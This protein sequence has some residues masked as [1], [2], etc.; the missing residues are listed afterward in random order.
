MVSEMYEAWRRMAF[1]TDGTPTLSMER[2]VLRTM[3]E[4]VEESIKVLANLCE[5]I[6][7]ESNKHADTARRALVLLFEN[8]DAELEA[9]E[10]S[11]LLDYYRRRYG[12]CVR[13]H[14]TG[15][16]LDDNGEWVECPACAVA[17]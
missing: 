15:H 4:E 11:E 5:A 7:D 9:I 3:F 1:K 13:C 16:V 8:G 17:S 10:S 2:R 12:G 6:R 14:S